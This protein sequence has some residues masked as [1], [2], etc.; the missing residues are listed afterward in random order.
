[1]SPASIKGGPTAP[2]DDHKQY[3]PSTHAPS[4][5]SILIGALGLASSQHHHSG[6]VR[7]TACMACNRVL[8]SRGGVGWRQC[9]RRHKEAFGSHHK[10]GPR[11]KQ[12]ASIADRAI[13]QS[14]ARPARFTPKPRPHPKFSTL[15]PAPFWMQDHA[16]ESAA[17]FLVLMAVAPFWAVYPVSQL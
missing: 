13:K 14:R 16:Q 11:K 9:K 7:A 17:P 15:S 10:R 3:D 6:R 5:Y 1:M 12:N 4:A 2:A 8:G